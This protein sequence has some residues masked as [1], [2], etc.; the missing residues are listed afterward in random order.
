MAFSSSGRFRR[1]SRITRDAAGFRQGRTQGDPWQ[2]GGVLVVRPG[3]Q[4]AY[5]HRS[6]NA[7]DHAPAGDVVRALSGR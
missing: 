7:G 6:Q 3:G 4:V 1:T 5:F 2:L